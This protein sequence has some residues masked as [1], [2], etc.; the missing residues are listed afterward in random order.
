MYCRVRGSLYY[1]AILL[2]G[3]IIVSYLRDIFEDPG[4]THFLPSGGNLKQAMERINTFRSVGIDGA[5]LRTCQECTARRS[6]RPDA[7]S[8]AERE[9]I[10]N[11]SSSARIVSARRKGAAT[12]GESLAGIRASRESIPLVKGAYPGKRGA[13]ALSHRRPQ[14]IPTAAEAWAQYVIIAIVC[15]GRR[16][17]V[18]ALIASLTA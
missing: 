7:V 18:F 2:S 13:D 14:C 1:T 5:C 6:L 15:R 4:R 8:S 12:C 9:T 3:I 16:R 17:L 10:E 11:T